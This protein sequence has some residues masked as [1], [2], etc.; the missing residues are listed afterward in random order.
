MEK[1]DEIISRKNVR[2]Q[3]TTANPQFSSAALE[4]KR[5]TKLE[6]LEERKN[7]RLEREKALKI[8][9]CQLA[10]KDADYTKYKK[11]VTENL[12]SSSSKKLHFSI[13]LYHFIFSN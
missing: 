8:N 10:L 9:K 7:R 6:L 3:R 5:V 4:A 12:P 1:Y 11:L 2:K 13:L